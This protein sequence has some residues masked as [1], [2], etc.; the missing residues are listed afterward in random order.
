MK[1][2]LFSI[3]VLTML[4]V[5]TSGM[6]ACAREEVPAEDTPTMEGAEDTPTMEDTEDTPTMEGYTYASIKTLDRALE[7][8]FVDIYFKIERSVGPL[9]R[10]SDYSIIA[11]EMPFDLPPGEIKFPENVVYDIRITDIRRNGLTDRIVITTRPSSIS[12][13]AWRTWIPSYTQQGQYYRN[14]P[15]NC[16]ELSE[17]FTQELLNQSGYLIQNIVAFIYQR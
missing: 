11:Y 6:T 3:L 13:E 7:D 12:V 8:K 4:L 15:A 10:Q 5:V 9:G 14:N 1:K 16:I 2:L 17:E